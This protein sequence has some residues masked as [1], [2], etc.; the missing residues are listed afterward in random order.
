MLVRR[1]F[2]MVKKLII[3]VSL[4]FILIISATIYFTTALKIESAWAESDE[5]LVVLSNKK[6]MITFSEKINPTFLDPTYIYVTKE[7]GE[8]INISFSYDEESRT[9]TVKPPKAG[10]ASKSKYTLHIER[11]VE[12]VQGRELR[13]HKRLTFFVKE[14]LPIVAS[15]DEL[16]QHFLN[17]LKEQKN[18]VDLNGRKE[19]IVM[20]MAKD[21]GA[22][23][24]AS[25]E[26]ASSYSETNNQVH[27]VDEADL[28][29]TNGTHVFQVFDGKVRIVKAVPASKMEVVATLSY[30]HSFFPNEIFL[31]HNQLVVIGNGSKITGNINASMD[32]LMMPMFHSTKAIIYD[33]TIPSSPQITREVELE[34][35]LIQSRKK[36]GILYL[37]SNHY[38]DYW[39]LEKDKEADL[40]PRYSDSKLGKDLKTVDYKKIQYL[41]QSKETNYTMITSID[42]EKINSNVEIITY[43]GS[44]RQIFMSENNL[45]LAVTNYPFYQTINKNNFLPNTTI[46][47]F[48]INGLKV[49]FYSSAEV[50]G[51]V[52]NQFSMDEY[53]GYFRIATTEGFAWDQNSPSANHLYILDENLVEVGKL[54]DLARGERIYSARFM[55]NRIYIVTFKETD[56]LFVI[57][58]KDPKNPTVLG[59]LK[60]PGFSNYL[61]P[62]DENHLIGFGHDTQVVNEKGNNQPIF[63]TNGVKISLFDVSD[64]TNPKEKF[65][66]IIG[67]RGT[68]SSLNHDHKALLFDKQRNLFAF[69]ISVYKNVEGEQF[70]QKFEYQGGYVYQIDVNNGFKLQKK[71]THMNKTSSYEEWE[72]SVQRLIFIEDHLYVMSPNKISSHRMKDFIQ[73]GEVRLN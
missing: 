23:T 52:L 6:W 16:N 64:M 72:N 54:E 66:E 62:Y 50:S 36:D 4:F 40:R 5:P 24:Q 12:S 17:I 15:K 70:E 67:G 11:Q 26:G 38:P 1:D 9:L 47:K 10:Y 8:K 18:S 48:S 51:T 2:F 7:N 58:A 43:L 14:T 22:E 28:I 32:S 55:G 45:Y 73:I 29:K 68:Y 71:I 25:G 13:K 21:S 35:Q 65:S 31:H 27:G 20:E 37:I 69:P 33:V 57:D 44:G 42:L 41:P 60:I 46:Y 49:D 19:N 30:D 56:P 34:G 3:P 63:L 61:H 59:E 53:N 39:M